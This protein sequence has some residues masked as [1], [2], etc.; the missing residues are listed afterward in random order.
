MIIE[1][2]QKLNVD[3]NDTQK[4]E[5]TLDYLLKQAD[6]KP[7]Y[8]ID[9]DGWVYEDKMCHTSHAFEVTDKVRVASSEDKLINNILQNHFFNL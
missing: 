2:V 3:L 4:K 1:A 9:T 6:W 5:V 7:S 8:W